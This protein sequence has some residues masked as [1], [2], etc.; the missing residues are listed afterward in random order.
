MLSRPSIDVLSTVESNNSDTRAS[1]SMIQRDDSAGQ[2]SGNARRVTCYEQR[3]PMR[4]IS[5]H[6]FE[7]DDNLNFISRAKV[8]KAARR[9]QEEKLTECERKRGKGNKG[10]EGSR[11]R[12]PALRISKSALASLS[13][14]RAVALNSC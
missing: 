7:R 14:L 6:D 9:K 12:V 13:N 4:L 11:T 1:E 3:P 10:L 8:E 2:I 5:K